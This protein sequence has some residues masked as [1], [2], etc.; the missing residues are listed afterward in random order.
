[1]YMDIKQRHNKEDRYLLLGSCYEKL[2]SPAQL[3]RT[4]E[5]FPCE[6]YAKHLAAPVYAILEK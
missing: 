3:P 5:V 1:M 2:L 4:V 6:R